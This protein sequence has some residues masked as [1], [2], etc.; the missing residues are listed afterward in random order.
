MTGGRQQLSRYHHVH[1][2]HALLRGYP[3]EGKKGRCHRTQILHSVVVQEKGR[4]FWPSQEHRRGQTITEHGPRT[5]GRRIAVVFTLVVGLALW[6]LAPRWLQLGQEAEFVWWVA[7]QMAGPLAATVLCFVAARRS[8][9]QDVVAWRLFGTGSSLYL[10][11][12]LMLLGL[13]ALG[14]DV[15]FPAFPEMA[16]FVM[17]AFFAVGMARYGRM[18]QQANSIRLLTFFLVYGA[19]GLSNLTSG[20]SAA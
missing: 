3:A 14:L 9:G 4:L 7:P 19:V 8:R 16:Y 13:S 12:N 2:A 10:A 1:F 15:G 17:A 5:F 20:L 11:G 18:P 6:A